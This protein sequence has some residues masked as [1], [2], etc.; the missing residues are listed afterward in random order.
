MFF[1]DLTGYEELPGR[2][3]H[4]GR[5][6]SIPSHNARNDPFMAKLR[7]GDA[8]ALVIGGAASFLTGFWI[9]PVAVGMERLWT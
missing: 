3:D 7:K 1:P 8:A 6:M 5:I 2:P 9:A 4:Y